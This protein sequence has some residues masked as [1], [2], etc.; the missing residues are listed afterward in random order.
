MMHYCPECEGK[1][2]LFRYPTIKR[3]DHLG[4]KLVI[5]KCVEC[6]HEVEYAE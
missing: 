1:M 6:G 5:Y 3:F 4:R 2:N